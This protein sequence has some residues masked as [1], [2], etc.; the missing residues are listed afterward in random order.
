MMELVRKEFIM[1]KKYLWKLIPFLA[2]Y[3]FI[4]GENPVGFVMLVAAL[5]FIFTVTSAAYDD[6]NRT[7]VLF[8]SLPINRRRLVAANYLTFL[9]YGTVNVILF[10][11]I[12]LILDRL[13]FIPFNVEPVSWLSMM[14]AVISMIL[15]NSLYLPVYFKWGYI[16]SRI[17]NFTVFLAIF[18]SGTMT[19][20]YLQSHP[21]AVAALNEAYLRF[22]TFPNSIQIVLPLVI[23]IFVMYLSYLLSVIFYSKREF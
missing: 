16:K 4:L 9:I 13:T 1:Q 22:I 17:I 7:D 18:M 20:N 21:E 12:S 23:T 14:I 2:I 3:L 11:L 8:N 5:T 6:R 10:F 15:L 19:G